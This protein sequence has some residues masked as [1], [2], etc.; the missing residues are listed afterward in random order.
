[1]KKNY[2]LDMCFSAAWA[3]LGALLRKGGDSNRKNH[4]FQRN[5]C[6]N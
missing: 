4:E 2:E 3:S 6:G 5:C 1:M